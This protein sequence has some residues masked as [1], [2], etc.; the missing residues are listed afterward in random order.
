MSTQTLL[1]SKSNMQ[2]Q[3]KKLHPEAKLPTYALPGDAGMDLYALEHV[4]VA[5]GQ[6]VQIRSGLAMAIP[7]GYVGLIWDKSGLS[8]RSGLKTLGG[9]IDAGYRGEVLV[10]MINSST[11]EYVVAAGDKVAQMLIQAVVQPELVTVDELT[12]TVRGTGAFGSTGR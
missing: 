11:A 5:P 8:H 3:I 12:E 6:R 4:V 10:G 7:F 9:V 2:L 1:Y